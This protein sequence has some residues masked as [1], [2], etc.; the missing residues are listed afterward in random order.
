MRSDS[1]TSTSTESRTGYLHPLYASS[2][3]EFGTPVQL[4]RSGSWL[5]RRSVPNTEVFDAMGLYPICQCNNWTS[6]AID[7]CELQHE[8]ICFAAVLDPFGPYTKADLHSWFPDLILPFKNHYVIDLSA[9]LF[10]DV[11]PHHRRYARKSFRFVDIEVCHSPIQ[12]LDDW[13]GLYQHLVRRHQIRGFCAFSKRCFAAQLATPGLTALRASYRSETV[14]MLLCY[15]HND[16]ACYHLGAS[17]ELGYLLHASF[18]LFWAAIEHY[19]GRRFRWLNL[20]GGAG[21]RPGSDDTLSLFKSGWSQTTRTA[22]FVGKI[23][24]PETYRKLASRT[25]DCGSYFPAYRHGEFE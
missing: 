7:L 10:R 24:Q 4:P 2:F 14:G 22:Y 25:S 11:S 1:R 6:L 21:V 13:L 15:E 16:V 8:L 23:F 9:P 20:G 12:W 5:L 17:N 19:A 18:G 3:E